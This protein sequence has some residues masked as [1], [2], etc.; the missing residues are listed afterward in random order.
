MSESSEKL[1]HSLA[2]KPHDAFAVHSLVNKMSAATDVGL[3]YPRDLAAWQAWQ[4]N[5]RPLLQRLRATRH[6]PEDSWVLTC[7]ANPVVVVAVD[8]T[9]PSICAAL[10]TPCRHIASE[11][12]AILDRRAR[13]DILGADANV[14]SFSG[15]DELDVLCPDVKVAV[16]IGA[17]LPLGKMAHSLMERRAGHAFV[18]Q[19]GLLTPHAPPLPPQTTLLAWSEDDATFW[20]SSRQEIE[21]LNV[22]SQ[23]FWRPETSTEGTQMS[24]GAPIFLGQL[25]AAE[26][27]RA[28]LI[29]TTVGFCR[30]N[31]A[32]YRPHPSE[33]DKTSRLVHAA[34][35]RGGISFDDTAQALDAS[36]SPVVAIFSSGLLEAAA[37]GR[38]AFG[39]HPSAPQWINAFWERYSIGKWGSE[40][41][42][43][44][45]QPEIEPALHIANVITSS[46][47]LRT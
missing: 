17:H 40:P 27:G 31:Q 11:H 36:C 45:T 21:T 13:L 2:W 9:T 44:P 33:R 32:R 8:G 29:R 42:V 10:E 24:E 26:L 18:V 46:I 4:D 47:G 37:N 30:R 41:T 15:I 28:D 25:H 6:A 1:A 35:R 12:L 20:K 14:H 5:R 38:P 16:T 39:Y 43:A 19:H 22:G 34:M 3:V 7:G 23:L